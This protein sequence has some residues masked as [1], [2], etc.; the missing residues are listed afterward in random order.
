[1]GMFVSGTVSLRWIFSKLRE[2]YVQ[3]ST[4]ISSRKASVT[5]HM[6]LTKK[7]NVQ[8]HFIKTYLYQISWKSAQRTDT[9]TDAANITG[10]LQGWK[11][12]ILLLVPYEIWYVLPLYK[13]TGITGASVNLY[14]L[15]SFVVVGWYSPLGTSA[16]VWTI[17][18]APGDRWVWSIWWNENLWGKPKYTEKTCSSVTL[19]STNPTWPGIDPGPPRW[20]TGD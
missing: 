4:C 20:E 13:A 10:A 5:F 18:S 2:K 14:V 11:S 1:M 9:L 16:T 17:V 15:L 8:T 6:K 12:P 3:K 7:V 19:S